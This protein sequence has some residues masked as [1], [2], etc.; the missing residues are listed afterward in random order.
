MTGRWQLLRTPGILNL[1]KKT[2]RWR[3]GMDHVPG[4]DHHVADAMSRFPVEKPEG[5]KFWRPW[6]PSRKC[7]CRSAEDTEELMLATKAAVLEALFYA[8][9]AL[10][11]STTARHNIPTED[12]GHKGDQQGVEQGSCSK[13]AKAAG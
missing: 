5:N 4:K 11:R 6:E 7:V 12:A 2:L 1:K 10:K 13:G 9:M 8:L 3:L